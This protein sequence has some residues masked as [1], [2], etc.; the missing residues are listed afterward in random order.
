MKRFT[1]FLT[2]FASDRSAS[3]AIEYGVICAFIF[4][5]IISSVQAFTSNTVALYDYIVKSMK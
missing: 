1:D 4:L 3:T 5:V 2:R